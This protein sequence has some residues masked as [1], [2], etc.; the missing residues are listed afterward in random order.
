MSG[1]PV[2]PVI[3][4]NLAAHY[5]SAANPSAILPAITANAMWVS[6]PLLLYFLRPEMRNG[7]KGYPL[8]GRSNT[9]RHLP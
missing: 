6:L 2:L 4:C 8:A 1:Q 3:V 7:I 9:H 5:C